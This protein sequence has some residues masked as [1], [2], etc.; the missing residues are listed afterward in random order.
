MSKFNFGEFASGGFVRDSELRPSAVLITYICTPQDLERAEVL[1][2]LWHQGQVRK[3]TGEPYAIHPLEVQ[4]I[5]KEYEAEIDVQIAALLHDVVEDVTM[6]DGELIGLF[7]GDHIRHLVLEV[8]DVSHP[9]DGN[10]SVR[11]AID[12]EHLS[13][14]SSAGK[15]IKLADLISNTLSIVEHDPNF[16]KKKYLPEKALLLGVLRDSHEGLWNHAYNQVLDLWAQLRLQDPDLPPEP[17]R[18]FLE[19]TYE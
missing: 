11:K 5:L 1:S 12:R 9:E 18:G 3:Y 19:M 6:D 8:T 7:F 2:S 16:A 15:M 4:E 10:R 13:K 17:E 14:A